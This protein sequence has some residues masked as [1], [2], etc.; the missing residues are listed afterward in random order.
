ME[1]WTK[2]LVVSTLLSG[3]LGCGA[4]D[5]A[6]DCQRICDK[7]KECIDNNYKVSNCVDYCKS[8]A[9]NNTSYAQKV[10]DCSAC[11]ETRACVQAAEC[12]LKGSCPSLP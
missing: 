2:A 10:N 12:Y 9:E 5:R 4:I 8:N 11:F 7:K 6:I 1:K 3:V